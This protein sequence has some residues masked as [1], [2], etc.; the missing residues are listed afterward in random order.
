MPKLPQKLAPARGQPMVIAEPLVIMYEAPG[1]QVITN[2]HP[3]KGL[4]HKA[5]GLL[6]CDLVRHVGRA[7][8]VPEDDVWEWVDRE[9]KRP[10]TDIT[11]PS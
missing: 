3:K 11:N 5:Y 4:T 7:Y 1:G 9:R 10:T 2:I 6:I 8:K